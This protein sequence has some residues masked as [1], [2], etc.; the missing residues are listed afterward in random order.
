MRI[1]ADTLLEKTVYEGINNTLIKI[2]LVDSE[3]DLYFIKED[4][5]LDEEIRVTGLYIHRIEDFTNEIINNQ[6][7]IRKDN[8]RAKEIEAKVLKQEE[9]QRKQEERERYKENFCNGFT[10]CFKPILKGRIIKILNKQYRY[11]GV[12]RSRKDNVVAYLRD[13]YLPEEKTVKYTVK[14]YKNFYERDIDKT[15]DIYVLINNEGIYLEITKTEYDYANYIL[16]E[17]GLENAK[18]SSEIDIKEE[19]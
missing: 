13:N 5:K 17:L 2:V 3:K 7:K 4:Y 9:E 11:D 16:N 6:D 8:I 12:V 10:D 1:N 19:K 14:E 18:L 15:K